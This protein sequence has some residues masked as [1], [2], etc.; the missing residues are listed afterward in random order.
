MFIS[1]GKFIIFKYS[2]C[3]KT[4]RSCHSACANPIEAIILPHH[5]HGSLPDVSDPGRTL[6]GNGFHSRIPPGSLT[7]VVELPPPSFLRFLV[8]AIRMKYGCSPPGGSNAVDILHEPPLSEVIL[9]AP[10]EEAIF[11]ES[12]PNSRSTFLV[13]LYFNLKT[14]QSPGKPR[15]G[16]RTCPPCIVFQDH[17]LC[18]LANLAILLP[19]S[20]R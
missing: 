12:R 6:E 3:T 9:H 16:R 11:W 1:S 19:F 2:Y 8:D 10:L 20:S 17:H 7:F 4:A 18:Q 13:C 5:W 14:A 15:G